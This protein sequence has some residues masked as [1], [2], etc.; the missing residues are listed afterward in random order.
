MAET[1]PGVVARE[2]AIEGAALLSPFAAGWDGPAL[3]PPRRW[4]AMEMAGLTVHVLCVGPGRWLLFGAA[5]LA[6]RLDAEFGGAAA[7]VEQSDAW[8]ALVLSGERVR[9]A[10]ARMVSFDLHPELF[11][12]GHV[13]VSATAHVGVILWRLPDE[14]GA[15]YSLAFPRSFSGAV[16][17]W[18]EEAAA[19]FGFEAVRGEANLVG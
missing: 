18:L 9:D 16:T 4:A 19:Q 8:V 13:A 6:D 3:P 7:I 2:A 12:V 14:G 17:H 15:R 1:V 5:G 11:A 10:L